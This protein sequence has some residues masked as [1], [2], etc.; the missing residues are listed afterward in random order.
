MS[1]R[2]SPS[3]L[4]NSNRFVPDSMIN[5]FR[6]DDKTV[7]K[8]CDP[9]RLAE[10]EALRFIHSK[11]SLPVPEVYNAYVDESTDRGVIV[12]EYIDGDVFQDVIE[13]MDDERREKIALELQRFMTELRS[14]EG[15]FIGSVDGSPCEDP[16]FCAEQGVFGPYKTEHEFNE[17]LILAMNM[18]QTNSWVDHVA[19]LIR[20]IPS[21]KIVLTHADLSPRNIIVKGD[22]ITGIIDWEMAGFY[23]EYW[24]YIKAMYHPDWQSCWIKEGFPD[25]VLKPFYREHA[26]MLHMQ[27]VV[28]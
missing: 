27:E 7:V 21:H 9:T 2:I 12:L 10:A 13:E 25:L 18:S 17:G 28:W 23:P 22:K 19:K 3:E 1:R 20:A 8:L 6:V 5:V 16:V 14:F 24:E 11:T 26:V 15:E 4:T